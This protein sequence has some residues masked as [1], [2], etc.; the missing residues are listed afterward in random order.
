MFGRPG[1]PDVDGQRI[2]VNHD[3][4]A[5]GVREEGVW[6]L[7]EELSARV[8]RDR[9][10]TDPAVL[11]GYRQDQAR[12]VVPGHAAVLARPTSTAQVADV[13]QVA[14]AHG[15][16]VV[17][18]GAGSGLSGG[19][20]AIDGGL[21]LS[22]EAMNQVLEVHPG[23]HVAVVQAGAITDHLKQAA[24][25]HGLWYAPDPASSA[26]STIGGNVASNAGGLCCVKYGTT[27]QWILGLELVCADGQVLRTGG[28][29]VKRSAG[30]DLTG[31]MIGSEGTLGV[32]CEVTTRLI[33]IPP[34]AGTLVATFN[35]LSDAGR[36]VAGLTSR[37]LPA[38]LEIMDRTTVQAVD[39]LSRMELDC[40]AA[41]H[42]LVQTDAPTL[43]ARRGELGVM[44]GACRLAGATY[45]ASTDDPTEGESLLQA[46]RLA[47]PAL[48]RLGATL[49]DDVAVPRSRLVELIETCEQ[50]A[51]RTGTT[52]AT[53]GH[54]GD[55]N[56][57]ATLVYDA[58]SPEQTRA[59]RIAFAAVVR[60]ALALGGSIS[61]EHGIGV[62]KREFLDAQF[63]PIS[64]RLH[65][66][67]KQLLDPAGLLNPGKGTT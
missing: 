33:P 45:V 19:A 34:A 6:R 25:K 35:T 31:L 2:D 26:F 50:I 60:A 4:G 47:Y 38:L 32:I 16:P 62:L 28:R 14:A 42:L 67:I 24:A 44:E 41:A 27:R 49:L 12:W 30:Y 9:I 59:A 61:G 29:T 48:E 40:D 64:L 5:P 56:L 21:I 65:R 36:A 22:L 52:I 17:P 7:A 1:V 10:S 39:E 18:R 46:R 37:L 63:S 11:A 23:D 8:G 15:I 57:H 20:A 53:F 66:G 51:I 54:A 58:T 43:E 3:A 13:L 55:G